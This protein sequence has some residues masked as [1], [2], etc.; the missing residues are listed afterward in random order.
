MI[1]F[2]MDSILAVRN[3]ATILGLKF[4]CSL[5]DDLGDLVRT[6]PGRIELAGSWVFGILED[7]A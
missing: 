5:L 3:V 7:S 2:E 1:E 4:V 6:F